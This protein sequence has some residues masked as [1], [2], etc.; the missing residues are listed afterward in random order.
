MQPG[1]EGSPA[2]ET[3]LWA[4]C[5]GLART[6]QLL[7]RCL[8]DLWC[9]TVAPSQLHIVLTCWVVQAASELTRTG[10]TTWKQRAFTEALILEHTVS[11]WGQR[12]LCAS[13]SFWDQYCCVLLQLSVCAC[14]HACHCFRNWYHCLTPW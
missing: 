12:G 1:L 10:I 8:Q 7:L 13:K 5:A 2:H 11:S 4:F 3:Q 14:T 9:Q 6:L